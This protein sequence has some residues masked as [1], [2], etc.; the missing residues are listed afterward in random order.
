MSDL[1]PNCK[2]TGK[3]QVNVFPVKN[4]VAVSAYT[5]INGEK[6]LLHVRFV[7]VC[8]RYPKSCKV[9]LQGIMDAERKTPLCPED[10]PSFQRR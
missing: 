4:K 2:G 1:C 7:M 6:N 10:T 9:S 5:A 3:Y 8:G